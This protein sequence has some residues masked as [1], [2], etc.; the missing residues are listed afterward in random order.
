MIPVY[1][2][3]LPEKLSEY[4]QDAISSTWVSSTGPYL[5]E[6]TSSLKDL[7]G[8]KH[9]LLCN[10]GTSATHLVSKALFRKFKPSKLIVPNNVYVAAI[11]SFLFDGFSQRDLIP[12]DADIDTWNFSLSELDEKIKDNPDAAVLVVHNIGNIVNVPYLKRKYPGTVFVE[13]NCEGFLGKYEDKFSGTESFASSISFYGN[14]ILTCGEGGAFITN[15]SE[16]FDYIK[17]VHGQGQ[18]ATR[19][20]HREL[21]VNYRMTNV[22]AAMLKAQ[23]ENLDFILENKQRVF[24]TYSDLIKDLNSPV[25]KIK[26]Q[27]IPQKTK[28]STWMAGVRLE[29]SYKISYSQIEY[30]FKNY[31]IEIRPMFYSICD[32]GHLSSLSGRYL[33]SEMLH[34]TCFILPSYPELKT[35]EIN[36]VVDVLDI[37]IKSIG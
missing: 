21:G 20:L 37:L 9:V 3:Y 31:D 34:E 8:V 17:C 14:K 29:S 15:D 12:I 23:L 25:C 1:K 6:V 19:F 22:Q 11:N 32:H 2:P 27:I 18:S 33:V 7:L 16:V 36:H 13:D 30:L 24:D 26:M 10:N 5:D 35:D 28:H 4:V